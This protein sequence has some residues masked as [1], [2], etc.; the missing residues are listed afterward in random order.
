MSLIFSNLLTCCC[1]K[2]G[3]EA[4]GKSLISTFSFGCE[5]PTQP[6]KA[7]AVVDMDNDVYVLLSWLRE[8]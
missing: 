8:G 6:L 3:K 1:G 5:C 7:W 2:F 4:K